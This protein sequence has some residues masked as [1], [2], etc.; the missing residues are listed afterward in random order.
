MSPF[1]Y[2]VS[3]IMYNQ[4]VIITHTKKKRQCDW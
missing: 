3:K 2:L 1:M 4:P